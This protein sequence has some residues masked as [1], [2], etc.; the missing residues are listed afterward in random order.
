V[1]TVTILPYPGVPMTRSGETLPYF[2][3]AKNRMV[4]AGPRPRWAIERDMSLASEQEQRETT[5]SVDWCKLARTAK[6]PADFHQRFGYAVVDGTPLIMA[7]STDESLFSKQAKNGIGRCGG[8]IFPSLSV[9]VVPASNFGPI[10]LVFD[11]RTVLNSLAPY[12]KSLGTPPDFV[13]YETDTWTPNTKDILGSY[14]SRTF[15]ELSGNEEFSNY[16]RQEQALL[17]LGPWM[18]GSNQQSPR[19]RS[20]F[21]V[22][23]EA[24]ARAAKWPRGMSIEDIEQRRAKYFG[25]KEQY[26]Y[27]EAKSLGVVPVAWAS[28]VAAPS[29]LLWKVVRYLSQ[30]GFEG[31]AIEVPMSREDLIAIDPK[32]IEHKAKTDLVRMEYA[33]RVH[34]AV[35]LH[36]SGIELS[37]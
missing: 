24:R 6:M 27:L 37:R 15:L 36:T 16:Y 19:L 30:F 35:M 4:P 26:G 1:F 32:T 29:H 10:C 2:S 12:R 34:D 23:K 17:S 20:V 7:H 9:G 5:M 11:P 22:A 21:E 31:T 25:K 14:S 18:L 13:V 8:L 33:W 28:A 3:V